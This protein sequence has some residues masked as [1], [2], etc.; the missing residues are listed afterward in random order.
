MSATG[1]AW[2]LYL[3]GSLYRQQCVHSVCAECTVP[4]AQLEFHGSVEV[5]LVHLTEQSSRP[6]M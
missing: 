2:A 3:T 5:D 4:A 1:S 6:S